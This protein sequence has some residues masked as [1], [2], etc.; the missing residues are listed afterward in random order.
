MNP[1][2][3]P[4]LSLFRTLAPFA[5]ALPESGAILGV[6]PGEKRVGLAISD[7]TR[8]IASPL[9]TVQRANREA[10]R[11]AIARAL[12]VRPL[13]GIV[14]GFPRM[15]DGRT[16]PAA[17]RASAYARFLCESFDRPTLL[18]DERLSTVAVEKML[19]E[20]DASRRRRAEIIDETAAG[21]V[22]QGVLDALRR[23]AQE[24]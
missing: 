3:G 15:M 18:W 9:A 24:P 13:S 14:V 20:G 17:Q 7:A 4:A 8:L 19:I 1:G 23:H 11:Q 21:Y 16:G 5:L 10:D 22:L 6:D 12:A 2:A